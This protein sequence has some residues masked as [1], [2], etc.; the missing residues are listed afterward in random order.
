MG[1]IIQLGL[2]AKLEV[3]ENDTMEGDY[4]MNYM[5]QL[6]EKKERKAEEFGV[7]QPMTTGPGFAASPG[8]SGIGG[9]G[10]MGGMGNGGAGASVHPNNNNNN[11]TMTSHGVG[12][13]V[14]GSDMGTE[15]G[16]TFPSM[17]GSGVMM[18]PSPG[19]VGMMRNVLPAT[20]DVGFGVV[21]YHLQ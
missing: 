13:S 10:G 21:A 18:P 2:G 15:F 20:A 11:N 1:H 3:L 4:N 16:S 5:L 17:A 7:G 12:L 19:S 8:G 9:M 6:M 14:Y